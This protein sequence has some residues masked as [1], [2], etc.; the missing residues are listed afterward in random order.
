MPRHCLHRVLDESVPTSVRAGE[1][2]MTIDVILSRAGMFEIGRMPVINQTEALPA[3]LHDHKSFG[4]GHS[5]AYQRKRLLHFAAESHHHPGYPA[6]PT[7]IAERLVGDAAPW[8]DR[9]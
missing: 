9:R 2:A 8:H 6:P 7:R 5:I 4:G 1:A 3:V